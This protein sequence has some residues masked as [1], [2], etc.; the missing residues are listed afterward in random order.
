M[1][2]T[3]RFVSVNVQP[4]VCILAAGYLSCTTLFLLIIRRVAIE[5]M[6]KLA[7]GIQL[8]LE[9]TSFSRYLDIY[10]GP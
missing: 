1:V 8:C 4:A 7:S 5:Q 3:N 6:V 2:W 10:H 9:F